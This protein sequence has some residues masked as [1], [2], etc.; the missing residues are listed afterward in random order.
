M[1]RDLPTALVD[2]IDEPVVRPFQALRI[3]L[4]DPLYVW[5][6]LGTL[7][8]AD[9]DGNTRNWIGAGGLGSIDTTG[10]ATDGSATGIRAAL[11]QVPAEFRDDI[12]QQ[13]VR[14][15]VF[16]VYAGALNE[17][18]QQVEATALIWKGRL[19]EYK[20]TDAGDTLTVEVAGE[21]R[22]IDQRRPAIKRF[23]D[24][25]QQR[26]HPGDKFFEYVSRMTE[27]SILWAKA[28]QTTAGVGGGGRASGGSPSYRGGRD[29]LL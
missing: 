19:D 20:I 13:A 28:E 12:A 23:T 3:E 26:K 17:T 10:E 8:F 1:S 22:G 16:E 7:I 25:Y 18:Y 27:V 2:A 24:E 14:G 4:P 9:A 21:S 29:G 5:T 15:V 6:G 11:Y